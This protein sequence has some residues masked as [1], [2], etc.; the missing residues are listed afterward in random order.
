MNALAWCTRSA[1]TWRTKR[2]SSAA[3]RCHVG[4]RT[5]RRRI[6]PSSY[7]AS[8]ASTAPAGLKGLRLAYAPRQYLDGVDPAVDR[9]FRETLRRL[10]DAGADIV[11]VDLGPDFAPLAERATWAIFFHETLPAVREFVASDGVPASFEQIY[12]GLGPHIKGRWARFVV[13]D[14]PAFVSDA[15]YRAVMATDRPALQRR[16]AAGAFARADALLFPT[17]PCAAPAIA[18]QWK[19]SVAGKE[20][21]DTFL[22]KNTCPT[23]CA[24]L[25]GIS[26]PMGLSP[27]RLPLGLE[28]DAD[29]GRDRELLAL[30][31]RVEQ[32]LG[33]I[34][35]PPG[36]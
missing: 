12:E 10:E 30:A 34:G 29:I 1:V 17:T 27:E 23:N 2:R 19:F 3:T 26:L 33:P 4:R 28:I 32:V 15:R 5:C 16:F 35:A 7:A 25:P 18:E 22:A 14:A 36:F 6:R 13:P 20:V 8:T 21:A 9:L 24:G 11:E 31:R